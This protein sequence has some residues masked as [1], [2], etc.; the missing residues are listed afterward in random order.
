LCAQFRRDDGAFHGHSSYLR[1]DP[2]RV[3]AFRA[4]YRALGAHR[5][6]GLSWRTKD[7]RNGKSRTTQLADWL[8]ILRL[9][10]LTFVDL[11]YGDTTAEREALQ[12]DHGIAVHHDDSVDPLRDL[13]AQAA[14][15]AALD[16]VV[17][18]QN[19]T[20]YLA[21]AVGAPVWA[22]LPHYRDWRWPVGA[23]TSPWLPTVRP[24]T[25]TVRGDWSDTIQQIAAA[26]ADGGP[27]NA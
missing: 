20:V 11:Q 12:R 8:P 15:I 24:F 22:L 26:L 7:M 19:A 14:Q 21:N 5:I 25:Q 27:A 17:T 18:V 4:Q 13:D 2:R 23:A 16:L 3:A 6:V 1:P 10:G 9:P